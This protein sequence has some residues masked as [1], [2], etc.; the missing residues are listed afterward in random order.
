M[1]MQKGTNKI[2]IN[3]FPKKIKILWSEVNFR[4]NIVFFYFYYF[5]RE[6]LNFILN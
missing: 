6:K 1:K 3:F 2:F 4:L 5:E